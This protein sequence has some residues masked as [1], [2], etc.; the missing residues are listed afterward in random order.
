MLGPHS[1][2]E[3]QANS[4]AGSLITYQCLT[5]IKYRHQIL[6]TLVSHDVEMSNLEKVRGT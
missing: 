2:A 4:K 3:Q 6:V 5:E 1:G